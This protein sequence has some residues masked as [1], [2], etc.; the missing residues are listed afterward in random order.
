[1]QTFKSN[2][3]LPP[4]SVGFISSPNTRGTLD[5]VWS[6]LSVLILCTWSVI[7]LNVPIEST[8]NGKRQEYTRKLF[9]FWTKL[10][11]MFINLAAPEWALGQAWSLYHSVALLEDRFQKYQREDSVPWSRSHIYYANMGGFSIRFDESLNE[12]EF[13]LQDVKP[14]ETNLFSPL[15]YGYPPQG[16]RPLPRAQR[17]FFDL[18]MMNG[19]DS[20]EHIQESVRKISKS[21]GDIN[22]K[23]DQYNIRAIRM[24]VFILS[25]DHFADEKERKKFFFNSETWFENIRYLCGDLWVLDANQL[26]LARERGIIETLPSISQASLDDRNKGNL[27]VTL[28]TIFQISWM[29][30]QLIVRLAL[31]L[32]SSQ[33]EIVTLSFAICSTITYLL[34]FNKPKD[35]QTSHTIKAAKRPSAEDLILIANAGPSGFAFARASIWIPNNILSR[36]TTHREDGNFMMYLASSAAM[37]IFGGIHCI[38]WNFKFPTEVEK[39]CW[40]ISTIITAV[41][42]PLLWALNQTR[43][44][45]IELIVM[46]DTDRSLL[47]KVA[48]VIQKASW[49]IVLVFSSA[50]LFITV[51]A[52]RS[53]A[54]LPPGAF[55]GTWSAGIPHVG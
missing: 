42:V 18:W 33:L 14:Y 53:L 23:P 7:H 32:P 50:R 41:T 30:I 38:A 28:L 11:W 49:L 2:C 10:K 37:I 43:G 9:L 36:D 52:F 39:L 20:P 15:N 47:A 6:C 8:P 25:P 12:P 34:L 51:E 27:F 4:E 3:T 45:V 44:K 17:Q 54:F 16:F 48:S 1:M 26:L 35:V 21:I 19:I 13:S 22:W 29:V 46:S 55:L 31:N 40:H 24:A 5:I